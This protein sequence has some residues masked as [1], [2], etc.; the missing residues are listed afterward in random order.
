MLY[1]SRVRDFGTYYKYGVVDTDDGKEEFVMSKK[2]LDSY[3][4]GIDVQGVEVRAGM[5][6]SVTPY[7]DTRYCSLAQT[8]LSTIV[9]INL[10]TYK[11]EITSISLDVVPKPFTLRL[12]DFAKGCSDA[13]LM[14]TRCWGGP[15]VTL[16]IDEKLKFNATTFKVFDRLPLRPGDDTCLRLDIREVRNLSM[17]EKVYSAV[18]QNEPAIAEW[19]IIDNKQRMRH[20]EKKYG[21]K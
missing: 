1:I 17:A 11:N 5:I 13:I 7:Q 19:F 12:S 10:V 4:R 9:G 8:K 16:V 15:V 18:S 14:S 21:P 3:K 20:M 2:L 6:R